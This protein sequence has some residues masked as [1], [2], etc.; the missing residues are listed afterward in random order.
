MTCAVVYIPQ[1]S[2]NR[3]AEFCIEEVRKVAEMWP[4]SE[5]TSAM[6]KANFRT[7]VNSEA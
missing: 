6:P 3:V 2:I 5:F 1:N 4:V 7:A